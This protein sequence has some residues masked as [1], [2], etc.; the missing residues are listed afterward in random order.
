MTPI[1]GQAI[2][3]AHQLSPDDDDGDTEVDDSAI[4]NNSP[5]VAVNSLASAGMCFLRIPESL[6]S[7][8]I[9]EIDE[10]VADTEPVMPAEPVDHRKPSQEIQPTASSK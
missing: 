6:S 10:D 5:A 9:K 7:I 1:G 4:E 3:P 8:L 2:S